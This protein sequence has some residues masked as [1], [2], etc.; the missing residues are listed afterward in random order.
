MKIGEFLT[1]LAG[2]TP[3]EIIHDPKND[4]IK[5]VSDKGVMIVKRDAA[6]RL[7]GGLYFYLGLE[8]HKDVS[9][10]SIVHPRCDW[11]GYD[12]EQAQCPAQGTQEIDGRRVCPEHFE[13]VKTQDAWKRTHIY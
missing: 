12:G 3:V 10:G 8:P 4:Y 13:I 9:M 1:G 6:Y 11:F 7:L 5:L 2:E